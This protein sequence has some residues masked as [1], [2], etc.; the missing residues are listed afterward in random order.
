MIQYLQFFFDC[1]LQI[2]KDIGNQLTGRLH[3]TSRSLETP[4]ESVDFFLL[5]IEKEVLYHWNQINDLL[6]EIITAL[7]T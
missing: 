7:I 2:R 1:C 3:K 4:I 5:K 6:P